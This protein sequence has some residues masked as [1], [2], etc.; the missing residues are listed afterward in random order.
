MQVVGSAFY[1]EFLSELEILLDA[2]YH[3]AGLGGGQCKSSRLGGDL[4]LKV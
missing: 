4:R 2:V 1:F 3:T